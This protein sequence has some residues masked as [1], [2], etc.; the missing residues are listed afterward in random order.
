MLLRLLAGSLPG[1]LLIV[2]IFAGVRSGVFTATESACVA[3][4]YA[5]LV[6]TLVYRGLTLGGLRSRR[7]AAPPAPRAW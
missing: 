1:L 2:I 3:V 4:I 5:L 6:T 7:S